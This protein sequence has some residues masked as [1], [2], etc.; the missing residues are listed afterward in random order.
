MDRIT[1]SAFTCRGATGLDNRSSGALMSRYLIPKSPLLI[2]ILIR[3]P[4]GANATDAWVTF[5]SFRPWLA[6]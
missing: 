4:G 3:S 1:V 5:P 6:T 2:R